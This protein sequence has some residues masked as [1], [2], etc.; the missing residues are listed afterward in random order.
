LP[1]Q[2]DGLATLALGL[3]VIVF[4]LWAALWALRRMRPNGVAARHEDCKIIR[5]LP[6]GQRERL[7]VVAIGAKQIVLGVGTTAISLLCEL[8]APLS[9]P[10]AANLGFAET[11]R[12][13]RERWHG[14]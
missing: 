7:L 1:Y 3:G 6:L 11:I 4:A 9:T 2:A 13:A 14:A 10:T 5:T 8:D 12:K